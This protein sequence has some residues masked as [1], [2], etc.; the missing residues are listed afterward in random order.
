MALGHRIRIGTIVVLLSAGITLGQSEV[1]SPDPTVT[2]RAELWRK[3]KLEKQKTSSPLKLSF[4]ERM[5]ASAEKASFSPS[6]AGIH[7]TL[8]TVTSGSGPSFGARYGLMDIGG[9]PV[10]LSLRAEASTRRY[11]AYGLDLG[12]L[13]SRETTFTLQPLSRRL[14]TEFDEGPLHKEPGRTFY[15]DL[16]YHRFP[17][18]DFYGI[19]P[20]SPRQNRSD[21]LYQARLIAVVWGMQLNS[22]L[23]WSVRGGVLGV[24][25]QP[26]T[27][28]NLP[29]VNQL[30]APGSAPGLVDAPDFLHVETGL[31]ADYRDRPGDARKGGMFGVLLAHFDD[32]GG[33]QFR[34]NRIAVET[35]QYIPLWSDY[36]RL[37]VRF[38]TSFDRPY[39]GSEVPFHLM[40]SLGGSSSIRG[41]NEY[42]FRDRNLLLLSAEYRWDASEFLQMV[43]FYDA[44]KVFSRPGDFDFTGLEKGVGGG[45]RI[46]S[47]RTVFLR[48]ELGHSREGNRLHFKLGPSF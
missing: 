10:D 15:L 46:K 30:C 36:R 39:S 9:L 12:E 43:L 33:D 28:E 19:G 40:E 45:I 42:R 17:Q 31:L 23:G 25:I 3:A 29:D 7:P 38:L 2:T 16:T 35:R 4:I 14:T 8:G 13:S 21:Y 26:G 48:A 6:P 34:F 41:F 27:D 1:S 44:G 47:G 24:N 22:W 5:L 18:E 32:R 11:Q 37:A 20:G